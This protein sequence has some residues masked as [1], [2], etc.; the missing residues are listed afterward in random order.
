[1]EDAE[2]DYEKLLFGYWDA[3]NVKYFLKRWYFYDHNILELKGNERKD[4]KEFYTR[5]SHLT[6]EERNILKE[7]F[8]NK[9]KYHKSKNFDQMKNIFKK[10]STHET[11]VADKRIELQLFDELF[12]GFEDK[13][14]SLAE[15]EVAILKRLCYELSLSE[16]ALSNVEKMDTEEYRIKLKCI[17]NKIM[18]KSEGVADAAFLV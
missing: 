10:L 6:N 3:L 14:E 18:S 9:K 13:L 12:D 5:L 11:K 7:S 1:M 17:F 16:K 2:R 8:Y 15:D 4:A